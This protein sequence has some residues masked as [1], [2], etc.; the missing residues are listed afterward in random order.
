M[1]CN[2]R[3]SFEEDFYFRRETRV[4]INDYKRKEISNEIGERI[5]NM[6]MVLSLILFVFLLISWFQHKLYF[7]LLLTLFNMQNYMSLQVRYQVRIA[8]ILLNMVSTRTM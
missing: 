4:K 1:V 7:L 2:S 8:I 5:R 3:Y 6:A